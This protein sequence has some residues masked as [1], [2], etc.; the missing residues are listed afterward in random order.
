MTKRVVDKQILRERTFAVSP[1]DVIYEVH[2][3]AVGLKLVS[4]NA[5]STLRISSGCNGN[6]GG[7]T[8]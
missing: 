8:E 4:S 1:Y 7:T 2:L 3:R 5:S 6:L